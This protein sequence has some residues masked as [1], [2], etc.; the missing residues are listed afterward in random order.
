MKWKLERA[1]SFKKRA[2]I[3]FWIS[4]CSGFS[5][6][7][8][9]CFGNKFNTVRR[10]RL[11]YITGQQGQQGHS[12]FLIIQASA[13]KKHS[14]KNYSKPSHE[15]ASAEQRG[16]VT[17][18]RTGSDHCHRHLELNSLGVDFCQELSYSHLEN[19]TT[20]GKYQVLASTWGNWSPC[21][22][23][24]EITWHNR[25]GKE[26]GSSSKSST[27]LPHRAAVPHLGVRGLKLT[28]ARVCS[29]RYSQEL[30]VRTSPSAH[31]LDK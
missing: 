3:I 27:E 14:R 12:P 28:R 24:W 29:E 16:N 21:G 2:S 7:A 8:V 6:S 23:R 4:T 22:C 31:L 25:C 20:K 9:F 18:F 10:S 1:S 15:G 17:H 13:S 19:V 26:F 30:R 11:M 5:S